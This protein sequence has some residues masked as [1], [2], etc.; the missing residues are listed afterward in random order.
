MPTQGKVVTPVRRFTLMPGRLLSVIAIAAIFIPYGPAALAQGNFDL[1]ETRISVLDQKTNKEVPIFRVIAGVP[2]HASI[3]GAF[4]KRTGRKVVVWQAHTLH[5]GTAGEFIYPAGRGWEET[6]YRVEADGYIPQAVY[7][8]KEVNVKQQFVF[9]LVEDKGQ[10]GKVLSPNGQPI[11][12][13]NIVAR[14]CP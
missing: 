6:A 10:E 13:A 7:G 5:I 14:R 12:G 3:A 2:A 9:R 4:E 1:N 11:A 8:V